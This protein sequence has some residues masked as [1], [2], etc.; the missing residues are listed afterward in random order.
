MIEINV[1]GMR[2]AISSSLCDNY[3]VELNI[4]SFSSF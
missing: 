1:V 3:I 4:L 2:M